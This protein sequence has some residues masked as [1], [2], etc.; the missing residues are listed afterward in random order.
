MPLLL[1][2]G[3]HPTTHY[4]WGYGVAKKDLGKL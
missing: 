1:F 4:N 3:N 2:T